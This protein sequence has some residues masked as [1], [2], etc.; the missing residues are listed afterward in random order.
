M[1]LF[2]RLR[3]IVLEGQLSRCFERKPEFIKLKIQINK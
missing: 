1:K 2:M 3:S